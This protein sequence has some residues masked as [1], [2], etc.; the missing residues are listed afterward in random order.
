MKSFLKIFEILDKWKYHYITAAVLLLISVSMRMLEPK[1][2]QIVVDKVIVFFLSDGK[3]R[4]VADDAVSKLIYNFLPEW[5]LE[6]L[7]I[8]L[9]YLGVIFLVV[10]LFRGLFSFVSSALSASSTEKAMKKLRDKLFSHIQ[11]LP[12]EYYSKTPTGELVQRCTGDVETI[13]KFSSMHVVEVLRLTAVFIGAFTMMALININYAL[14]AVM[15]VPVIFFGGIFFFRKEGKIWREH[16]K[17]QDKLTSIVQENL[18]GIRVVKA[19]AKEQYEI[20]KFT[21]MNKEKK[22]WGL[23]LMG[24]HRIFWPSSDFFVHL[25]IAISIFAG[26]YFALSNTITVGEF[27]AFYSYATLV[28]WPMRR[29]PQLISEMGMTSVAIDRLY[30]ILDT[31]EE[32]YEGKINGGKKILGNIEFKDVYFRYDKNDPHYVLNGASFKINACENIAL[33]GPTGS[34]K[35]TIISLLLRFYEPENGT[36]TIDG[37]NINEYSKT[38]LRHKFG[39]VL[40]KP[41][42]FSTTLK[43]NIAYVQPDTE[44]DEV[45]ESAKVA[46]I[47]RIIEEIF[48]KSYETVVGEKGVTLSGGQKQRVTLARTLLKNPDILV[49]D[50]STSSVDSETEF[51]IQKALRGI[52][53]DKTTIVIAHRITSIQD[54]DRIIVLDKGKVI[55]SG[56]HEELIANNGFYKKIYDIQVSIEDEINDELSENREASNV[57]HETRDSKRQPLNGKHEKIK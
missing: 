31:E 34:G 8:M 3:T 27:V 7:S 5:K 33:L 15:F 57:K 25:Q 17:R 48:P 9:I 51:E 16:E 29:V 28:T 46:N 44:L 2:L 26:G 35:S 56:T 55:E 41:F 36:I 37:K 12:L 14:I 32:K 43:D 38:Y 1:I 50:D 24:L 52:I 4:M 30:S 22:E 54:C 53:E 49:L 45:I 18:S 19:F 23:K 42:L 10:S 40:Q 47:H 6:N 20:E 39:V 21:S 11:Q 13:R